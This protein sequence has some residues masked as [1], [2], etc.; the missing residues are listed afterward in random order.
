MEM[1][2]IQKTGGSTFVVSLPKKWVE[3]EKL[4]KGSVVSIQEQKDNSLLITSG[5]YK[6]RN[7]HEIEIHTNENL[8][9]R[10]IEKYLLGYDV[11]SIKS[12][13]KLFEKDK[14]QIKKF[15]HNLIGLEII[16]E[17]SNRLVIQN[18]LN[19]EEVS[20]LKS[21]K[22]MYMVI[23]VMHNDV[24]TALEKNDHVLLRD[25]IQRDKE[26]NRLYFLVVRQIRTII[27]NP[28]L[29]DSEGIRAVDCVD[30]RLVANIMEKI[31]DALA[32]IAL[33]ML[34][35]KNM[36]S[37]LHLKKYFE[38]SY[39]IHQ[40]ASTALFKKDE[41]IAVSAHRL[42]ENFEITQQFSCSS[43]AYKIAAGLE[44]IASY[45]KNISDIVVSE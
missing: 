11:I 18:L 33:S 26:V 4:L 28:S 30:Y 1:R 29:Q 21:L 31:G 36:R 42:G 20:V 45:G 24:I 38:Q 3:R 40:M 34:S 17:F 39:E 19:P 32:E 13:T 8:E 2:K 35:V 7:K 41:Q 16:E 25:V 14:I 9:R 6:E 12:D 5:T 27:Q 22:R 44:K 23:S 43:A 10:L 37:I 15:L